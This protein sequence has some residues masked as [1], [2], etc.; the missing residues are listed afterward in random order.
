MKFQ[1]HDFLDPLIITPEVV[2]SALEPAIE[3]LDL[4]M[5]VRWPWLRPKMRASF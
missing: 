2:R 4:Y 5:A 1:A 3:S